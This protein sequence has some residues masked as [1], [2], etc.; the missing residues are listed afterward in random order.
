MARQVL[1]DGRVIRINGE[2]L[3]SEGGLLRPATAAEA[4]AYELGREDY[5][6]QRMRP[7]WEREAAVREVEAQRGLL[8]R[9]LG[10]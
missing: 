9:L 3:V 5:R 4:E 10:L 2:V 7:S 8:A 1:Q 6:V